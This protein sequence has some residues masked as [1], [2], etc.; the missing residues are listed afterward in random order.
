MAKYCNL[1]LVDILKNKCVVALLDTGASCSILRQSLL[2][3]NAQIIPE[4]RIK[5]KGIAD[6]IVPTLGLVYGTLK[7]GRKNVMTEFQVVPD[8]E[9][10]E[11][12]DCIV[13]INLLTN[14]I[15][16]NIMCFKNI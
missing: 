13:G 9:F 6:K 7:V 12:Y 2:N 1:N 10:P 5:L 8:N 11:N 15:I 3:K 4:L 14:S 16:N